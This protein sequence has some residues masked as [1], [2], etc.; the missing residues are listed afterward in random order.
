LLRGFLEKYKNGN[1]SGEDFLNYLNN[2]TDENWNTFFDD[3]YYGKGYPHYEVNWAREH[4]SLDI[5]LSQTRS[6]GE[7]NIFEIP[8]ELRIEAKEKDTLITVY[9][10]SAQEH[11]HIPFNYT[12][13]DIIVD[14]TNWILNTDAN[15]TD[16]QP[17]RVTQEKAKVYP[18]PFNSLIKIEFEQSYPS[19][20]LINI[21]RIDGTIIFSKS[22]SGKKITI[23]TVSWPD[24]I[25][26]LEIVENKSHLCKKII[27]Y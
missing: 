21:R 17:T 20:R 26:L 7:S 8:V 10:K 18:N 23:Q 1:A 22:F 16:V 2:N 5:E 25:Y 27:K 9:P 12:V 15:F 19:D 13:E 14:P 11:I 3:W 4:D 6:S 24:G